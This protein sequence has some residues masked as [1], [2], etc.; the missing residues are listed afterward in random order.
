MLTVVFCLFLSRLFIGIIQPAKYSV[1]GRFC[2]TVMRSRLRA[3]KENTG[4]NLSHD[5]R[6]LREA[7][8]RLVWFYKFILHPFRNKIV[9]VCTLVD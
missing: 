5:P 2:D 1:V 3:V 9:C 7:R 6:K 8:F 4:R